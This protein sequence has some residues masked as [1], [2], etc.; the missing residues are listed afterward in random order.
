LVT[1]VTS[2]LERNVELFCI[3]WS[4]TVA[5]DERDGNVE[6]VVV[7]RVTSCNAVEGKLVC[8]RLFSYFERTLDLR[9]RVV[10]SL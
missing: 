9:S 6:V 2:S 1:N 4:E 3:G 5:T 10:N 7:V 8:V